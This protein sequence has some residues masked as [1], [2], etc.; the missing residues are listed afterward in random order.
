MV[1]E[2]ISISPYDLVVGD[3]IVLD[4]VARQ[5]LALDPLRWDEYISGL[6]PG[7]S[8]TEQVDTLAPP[9]NELYWIDAVGIDGPMLISVQYPQG[10]T[11]GTP[12]GKVVYLD[13]SI[14]DKLFPFNLNIWIES[15]TKPTL[16]EVMPVSSPSSD[17]DIWFFGVKFKVKPITAIQMQLQAKSGY[18]VLHVTTAY[19]A[20]SS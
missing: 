12:Q 19:Q 14:A 16:N 5:I 4:N 11:R 9:A 8:D 20:T 2:D 10:A 3:V 7:A 6:T 13:Q 18:K 1:L 15:Q 17:S